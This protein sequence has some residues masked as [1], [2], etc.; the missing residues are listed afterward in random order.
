MPVVIDC[1]VKSEIGTCT[2]RV[3]II[4]LAPIGGF[5]IE[6]VLMTLM[7]NE[8]TD[9]R[10]LIPFACLPEYREIFG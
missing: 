2:A 3:N 4:R 6:A 10:F 9:K 1:A 8:A 5:Q 7:P